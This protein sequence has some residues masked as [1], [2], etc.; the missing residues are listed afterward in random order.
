LRASELCVIAAVGLLAVPNSYQRGPAESIRVDSPTVV[1][2]AST[3]H[4]LDEPY[5]AVDPRDDQI[6]VAV[7]IV[8]GS[9]LTFPDVLK[10]QTCASFAS[11]DGGH[12]WRR[13]DFPVTGCA[14]P[15]V[16]IMDDGHAIA[17]MLAASPAFPAQGSAGLLVFRS[18][19][20]GQTWDG[21][22]GLGASHDHAA[23]A[24]DRHGAHRGWIYITSHKSIRA[25]EGVRR[26]GP[27]ISRTRDGGKSFDDPVTPIPDNLHNFAEMPAVLADGTLVVSFVDGFY[28]TERTDRDGAFERR[29]AWMIRSS[30]GGHTFSVPLFVNDACGPPPGFRLSALAADTSGGTFRDRLYFACREKGGGAIVV[31]HSADRGERWSQPVA[32]HAP[33]GDPT[34]DERIPGLAVNRDGVLAVAWIDGRSSTNHHCEQRVFVTASLDG[35]QSFL[36]AAAV[37]S[38]PRCDDQTRVGSSTGGDYFGFA[39]AADGSFRLLWAEMRDGVK[40][41]VTTVIRVGS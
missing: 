34:V 31:N 20:R 6:W 41:L 22:V 7:A 25:D 33:D 11:I 2:R 29:R 23:M 32:V 16:V 5:I 36:P 27:W 38:T 37:S 1:A 4:P 35:G 39:P 9:A 10:D 15:W 26:Y 40:Q 12:T 30:D 17:S 3:Q 14:D 28:P 21:P 19:D 18:D 13:H 24:I 8:R